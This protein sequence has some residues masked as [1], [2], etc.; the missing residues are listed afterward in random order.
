MSET[1]TATSEDREILGRA[2]VR[3]LLSRITD[4]VRITDA[5]AVELVDEAA[6]R[7]H[8]ITILAHASALDADADVRD[9]ARWIIGQVG[10]QLGIRPASIHDLYIARGRGE[11]SG[12]TVPAMNIRASTF[13][14]GRALFAAAVADK[15]GALILEIARSEIGYTEQRPTEYVASLTAAAI[16]EGWSGPLFFQGDHVQ[17]NVKKY[18]LGTS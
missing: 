13:Q 1:L 17:I 7:E 5:G 2:P 15:V 14:T 8:A 16:R 12:F 10:D 11:V 4:A 18:N 6:L 9:T 3:D